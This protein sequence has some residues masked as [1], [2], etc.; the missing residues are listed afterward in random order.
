MELIDRY[1]GCLLG[2]AEGHTCG[3]GVVG[4]TD[5]A[6]PSAAASIDALSRHPLLK[7]LRPMLHDL[8]QDDW[9]DTAP[10]SAAITMSRAVFKPPSVRS[11]FEP[12]TVAMKWLLVFAA[13]AEAVTGLA[14]LLPEQG[15]AGK[16]STEG[17]SS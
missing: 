11:R 4:G 15:R 8:I 1:Q 7:G 10:I 2:L 17:K 6:A 9:V 16:T 12:R 5:L 13:I 14:L 3:R